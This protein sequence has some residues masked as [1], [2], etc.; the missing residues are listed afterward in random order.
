MSA[1]EEDEE[2][3]QEAQQQPRPQ[4]HT[5][6]MRVSLRPR[7]CTRDHLHHGVRTDHISEKSTV[8][9]RP[10]LTRELEQAA[11]SHVTNHDQGERGR[12]TQAQARRHQARAHRRPGDQPGGEDTPAPETLT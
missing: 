6:E 4:V 1:K 12:T 5:K 3:R 10:H 2:D 9:T 7:Q 11:P 8:S